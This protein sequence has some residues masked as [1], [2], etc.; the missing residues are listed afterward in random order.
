MLITISLLT[1]LTVS[2]IGVLAYNSNLLNPS[3]S[4]DEVDDLQFNREEEKLA[5]DT[6]LTLFA[7]WNISV[8]E[9]I[10][11]SEQTHMDSIGDLL[12]QYKLEDPIVDDSIGNYNNSILTDLYSD[13]IAQGINS[14]IEALKVGAFIEEMDIKDLQ[15][16]ISRTDNTALIATYENLMRGSRNHLRS[17]INTLEIY[18]G[19]YQ[20]TILSESEFN[21]IISTPNE[22]GNI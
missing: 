17:F 6:Y 18:G 19:S 4:Q 15:D 1:I 20:P 14:T 21:S 22:K 12:V 8:F 11:R 13:L 7:T 3:L 2:V 5:R 10:A 16:F 9:N